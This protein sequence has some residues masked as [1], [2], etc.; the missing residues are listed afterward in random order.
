MHNGVRN[1]VEQFNQMQSRP[2]LMVIL[3]RILIIVLMVVAIL[4]CLLLC[5]IFIKKIIA[6][7]SKK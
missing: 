1:I 4:G 6:L 5:I 2:S 3:G 7:L